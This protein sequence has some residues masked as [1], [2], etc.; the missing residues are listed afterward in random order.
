VYFLKVREL[1]SSYIVHDYTTSTGSE[2]HP[3]SYTIG[4]GSFLGRSCQDMALT[5][6]PSANAE[7]KERV[8]LYLYPPL[9]LHGLF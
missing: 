8:E 6:H 7:V 4:T 1:T 3:A 2:A 5:T 9:G